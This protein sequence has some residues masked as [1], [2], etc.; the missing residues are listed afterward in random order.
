M[1]E[2]DITFEYYYGNQANQ[3]TF[4]RIP[5]Q[6]FVNPAF[7]GLSSE[8]KVLY[9][10][11][12]DRMSLSIK[13]DWKDSGDRVFIYFTL[14]EIQ[15]LMNCGHNKGVRI[16]AE[17]DSEKGIG[18]IERIKQGLGKPSKIYVMNFLVPESSSV[19]DDENVDQEE[20]K[21]SE[22]RS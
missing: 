15:E 18:L 14:S 17:L 20:V 22:K 6:L 13:N 21:T 7:S 2:T 8:A 1:S 11:M 3:F 4:Y 19:T 16:L 5:K 12:L 9:G 10:L